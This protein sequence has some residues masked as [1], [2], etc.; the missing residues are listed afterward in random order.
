MSAPE[1]RKKLDGI[2]C[3]NCTSIITRRLSREKG[4]SNVKASYVRS[5]LSL[6]YDEEVISEKEIEALLQKM[7]YPVGKGR[8]WGSS[9]SRC[10]VLS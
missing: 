5:E 1:F 2:I 8:N 3:P 4:I 7:G 10:C 6:N 9:V